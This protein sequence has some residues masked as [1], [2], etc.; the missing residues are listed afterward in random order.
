MEAFL[1]I[2][3]TGLFPNSCEITVIGIYLTDGGRTR[4]IQLVGNRITADNLIEA[5]QDAHIIYTYNGTRFDIPFIRRRLGVDLT[6]MFEHCDLMYECWNN[7]LYGGL[8]SVEK[9]LK[10]RRR[11]TEINGLEAI[12]LWWRYVNSYDE[13]ALNILLEYNREDVVNLK[14]LKERLAI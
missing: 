12:K 13:K 3:T 6:T 4:F 2:E 9:Q 8:K 10:I 1:D 14:L 11:L 5:L 7:D